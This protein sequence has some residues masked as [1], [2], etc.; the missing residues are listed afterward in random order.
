[1]HKSNVTFNELLAAPSP[2]FAALARGPLAL[3][4]PGM[5][6]TADDL[7]SSVNVEAF[8]AVLA[9]KPPPPPPA[10]ARAL[11]LPPPLFAAAL[12]AV[13]KVEQPNLLPVIGMPEAPSPFDNIF[14]DR[15]VPTMYSG[16]GGGAFGLG[17]T[18]RAAAAT[19]AVVA[20]SRAQPLIVPE[21]PPT[22]Y[23]APAPAP[24]PASAPM[25]STEVDF[26]NVG[27]PVTPSPERYMLSVTP[28]PSPSPSPPPRGAS[29]VGP[30]RAGGGRPRRGAASRAAVP[31]STLLS[32]R[33]PTASNPDD[34][35][36]ALA[37]L[38]DLGIDVNAPP[39]RAYLLA[40]MEQHEVKMMS[41][42]AW[43]LFFKPE[44][45]A[46]L[47]EAEVRKV[48]KDRRRAKGTIYAQNSRRKQASEKN[49]TSGKIGDLEAENA[50]LKAQVRRLSAQL[51]AARR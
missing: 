22:M 42:L 33:I 48:K 10:L 26:A 49:K 31:A 12:P 24:A 34:V 32:P 5:V 44:V 28:S 45:K 8:L 27:V 43:K 14:N 21:Q 51:E 2:S 19:A 23:A 25:H 40:A 20:T 13:C 37:E 7:L 30:L 1:M 9:G 18:S 36:A 16:G 50:D 17:P 4:S 29:R 38:V 15:T 47:S 39:S 35:A 6:S 46:T 3:P 41:Q 11:P